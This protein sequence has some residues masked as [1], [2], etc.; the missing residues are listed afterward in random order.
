[1][2]GN[3]ILKLTM[4]DVDQVRISVTFPNAA[5]GLDASFFNFES[6]T[7]SVPGIAADSVVEFYTGQ[8]VVALGKF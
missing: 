6:T 4:S 1:M 8:V 5:S 2:T 3:D 7:I